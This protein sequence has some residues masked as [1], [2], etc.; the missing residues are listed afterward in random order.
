MHVVAA[1][2]GGVDSS[3]AA[4][5]LKQQGFE[6]VGVTMQVAELAEG[7]GGS[8]AIDDAREVA[9]RLG[10]PHHV[11]DFRKILEEEVVADF[12]QEYA[13]GRTPNPCIRCNERVKFGALLRKA[14][15]LGAERLAT[16][17]H[18]RLNRDDDG[19]WQL[20]KG[21]DAQK[22][23][24]YFLYRL[25]Q[26]QMKRVLMPVGEFTKEQ[27]R[28]LAR[29]LELP[30]ADKQESQEICFIPDDD[31]A[32]FLRKRRP[33]LFRSGPVLDTQGNELGQHH[34]IV[35]FTVGQRKGLGI[36]F[37]E[38]RYVV[39]IDPEAN[40]VI[41]GTEKD[42]YSQAAEVD[43]LHWIAAR[44]AESCL[45]MTVKIRHQ[46]PAAAAVVKSLGNGRAELVFDEP[47]WAITPGQAAVFYQG[48]MVLGG[49]TI[50]RGRRE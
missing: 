41:L 16:G 14:E 25:T 40:A 13:N 10:I 23:Q 37:G 34:G 4:A 26:E 50:V 1:M 15:E 45:S 5:L 32:G 35:N 18:A 8:K 24:S 2:S 49:G 31:Y 17:H 38:R 28:D 6:V 48:D 39:C 3:V 9:T 12:C 33:E 36:A 44:P 30:I 42:V 47:Q 43:G 20:R 19:L 27:V 21:K 7:P 22:D 46:G 11:L 29:E